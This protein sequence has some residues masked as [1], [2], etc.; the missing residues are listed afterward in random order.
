MPYLAHD[1]SL[2]V[3]VWFSFLFLFT[4]ILEAMS[5]Q[6]NRDAAS[7]SAFDSTASLG[8]TFRKITLRHPQMCLPCISTD[9]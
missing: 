6:A 8:S 3:F 2:S 9:F 5:D 4:G 1:N 7:Q